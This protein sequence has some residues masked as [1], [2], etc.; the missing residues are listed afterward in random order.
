MPT[1]LTRRA[2]HPTVSSLSNKSAA[3]DSNPGEGLVTHGAALYHPNSSF[4]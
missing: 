4:L 2:F 1:S 3:G